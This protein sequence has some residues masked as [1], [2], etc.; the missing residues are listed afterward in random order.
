MVKHRLRASLVGALVLVVVTFGWWWL[1]NRTVVSVS[2]AP[3]ELANWPVIVS[4]GSDAWVVGLSP[5]APLVAAFTAEAARQAG[6]RLVAP[7]RP[8]LPLVLR[9]EFEDALQGVYG[10]DSVVRMAHDAGIDASPFQPVC[11]AHRVRDE[12]GGRADIYFVPFE[13]PTFQQ[14]RADL[15]PTEPEHAGIG[16][17][18]PALLSPILIVGASDAN[19]DRWWPLSFDGATDCVA[20]LV[21][22][23]PTQN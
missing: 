18:D 3:T 9:A 20:N 19:L 10:T 4:D 2:I 21:T 5:P 6:R 14:L 23:A 15:T 12:P 1:R 13:S 7:T 8:A 16:V 11:L 22:S 17:Y